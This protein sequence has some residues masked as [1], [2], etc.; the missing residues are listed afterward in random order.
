MMAA[1]IDLRSNNKRGIFELILTVYGKVGRIVWFQCWRNPSKKKKKSWKIEIRD[2]KTDIQFR[3]ISRFQ[4]IRVWI[5]KGQKQHPTGFDMEFK[6]SHRQVN[7]RKRERFRE[8]KQPKIQTSRE[9][10]VIVHPLLV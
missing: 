5:S 7:G 1:T 8:T 9:K 2:E 3:P 6:L 4:R 10:H